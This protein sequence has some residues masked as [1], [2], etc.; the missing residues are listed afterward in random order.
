M[1][2]KNKDG[3]LLLIFCL[4]IFLLASIMWSFSLMADGVAF[5]KREGPIIGLYKVCYYDY[6]GSEIAI[7]VTAPT[8]CPMN[9]RVP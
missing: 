8:I 5:F 1:T 3:D 6:L 4:L 7:T 2:A 9:I